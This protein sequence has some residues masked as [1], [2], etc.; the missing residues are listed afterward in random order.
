MGK[1]NGTHDLQHDGLGSPQFAA[2]VTAIGY[3]F[4]S[5]LA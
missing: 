3:G 4:F 2:L 5:Q 1:R